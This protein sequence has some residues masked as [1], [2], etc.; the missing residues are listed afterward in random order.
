MKPGSVQASIVASKI[1][2]IPLLARLEVGLSIG[3]VFGLSVGLG[4]GLGG[5]W[6]FMWSPGSCCR[7]D[8]NFRSGSPV[9]STTPTGLAS[10]AS[11]GRSTSSATPRCKT[12]SSRLMR[13]V[14]R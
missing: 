9:F 4:A 2:E 3:V 5:A 6:P 1:A 13:P 7:L 12:T 10:C 8:G 11:P 14:I